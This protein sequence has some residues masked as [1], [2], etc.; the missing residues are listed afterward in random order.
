MESTL[1]YTVQ[2]NFKNI[3]KLA[4]PMVIAILIPQINLLT[5]TFFIGNYSPSNEALSTQEILS[6]T[7]LSGIFY[8]VLAMIG[9][10]MSSGVLML[11]SRAAGKN[12]PSKISILFSN[13]WII[14]FLLSL[15]LLISSLIFVPI[16]FQNVVQNHFIKEA[17]ISFMNI[18]IWGLPFLLL[19][20]TINS[21]FLASSN[22]KLIIISSIFQTIV[23]IILD[24]W[25][26]LGNNG[27]PELGLNG[28]AI[29]SVIAEMVYFIVS[30]LVFYQLLKKKNLKI[31]I[32]KHANKR[33]IKSIF[34]KSSPLLFQYLLSVGS[35]EVFFLFVEHLGKAESA[36][37]QLLRT[38]F[39]VVGI[40]AF[41]LGA[42]ANSMVSNLI[43][44]HREKEI[45]S[46]LLKIVSISLTTAIFTGSLLIFF[47]AQFLGILTYDMQLIEKSIPALRVIVVS[48]C[49]LSV[50]TVL[51][52][53]ILGTGNTKV[54]F[55]IEFIGIAVYLIYSYIVIEQ[56]KLNL[57]WAWGAEFVYWIAL[58]LMSLWYL[59]SGIWQT[60]LNN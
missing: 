31:S 9:N 39:G 33:I 49:V 17:T 37:S 55:L 15:F 28:S 21:F 47:P 1:N 6:A 50:G 57:S 45:Y 7:G 54:S 5:N 46:L 23:N 30:L 34:I 42:V 60:K 3:F 43:G 20:Q 8:L 14:T 13:S 51:F 58:L 44:Q 48:T 4:I 26:I 59:R 40:Q 36:A 38:V 53:A 10:G 18:R 11:L 52:N 29:A 2:N 27:F 32:F 35:W 25:L 16:I 12:N 24:Y 22:S 19:T 41:A 56:L